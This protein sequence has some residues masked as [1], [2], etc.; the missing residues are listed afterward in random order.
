MLTFVLAQSES[1][2]DEN[3]LRN[4][5]SGTYGITMCENGSYCCGNSAFADTCCALNHGV[6]M[7]N[8]SIA[9]QDPI[10]FQSSLTSGIL[11]TSIGALTPITSSLE[12]PSQTLSNFPSS[13]TS[14]AL[15]SPQKAALHTGAI[16]GGTFGT[17]G[18]VAALTLCTLI[19]KR[20]RRRIRQAHQNEM[21]QQPVISGLTAPFDVPNLFELYGDNT[22]GEMDGADM[23]LELDPSRTW[24][25]VQ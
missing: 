15:S 21:M 2:N 3:D 25:E 4:V 8:E 1:G 12:T 24:H 17:I 23:I 14:F 6:F 7:G 10:S 9:R 11:S 16:L 5:T 22:H 18:G 20:R 13:P 19:W